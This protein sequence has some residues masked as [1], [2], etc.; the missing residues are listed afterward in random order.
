MRGLAPLA[1][2]LSG[3]DLFGTV[4]STGVPVSE[5]AG[6]NHELRILDVDSPLR[7]QRRI[8]VLSTPEV[9]SAYVPSHAER[10]LL[11]GEHWLFFKLRESEWFV[12]RL[13]SPE[14]AAAGD[15]A[16]ETLRPLR[17]LDWSRV[18]IPHRNGGP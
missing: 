8:P 5:A 14:P 17:D 4:R 16:P 1:L 15:A 11:I 7:S 3:C 13:Q 2:L 6:G 10:D 9:F 18:V 12:D